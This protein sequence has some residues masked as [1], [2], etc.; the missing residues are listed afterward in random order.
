MSSHEDR[1]LP[2]SATATGRAC[3]SLHPAIQTLHRH[4][5]PGASLRHAINQRA[6]QDLVA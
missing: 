5:D 6:A 3:R 2:A 1:S 4:G